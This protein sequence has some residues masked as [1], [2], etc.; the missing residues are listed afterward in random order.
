[1]SSFLRTLTNEYVDIL[2]DRTYRI[3]NEEEQY[4][5]FESNRQQLLANNNLY[6]SSAMTTKSILRNINLLQSLQIMPN[7][8]SYRLS[9]LKQLNR[10][11]KDSVDDGERMKRY[12]DF[13]RVYS[14][15][16]Q[17]LED[18]KVLT[19]SLV[20]SKLIQDKN[21]MEAIAKVT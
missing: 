3:V 20:L 5:L 8:Y 4:I 7:D 9:S 14:M 17:F 11:N 1:M 13:G 16:M 2:Q 12:E 15:Y 6:E 18:H 19:P 21:T 10:Q